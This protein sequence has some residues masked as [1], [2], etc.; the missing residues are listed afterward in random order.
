MKYLKSFIEYDMFGSSPTLYIE[1]KESFGTIFGLIITILALISYFV[2]G[3]YFVLE[4]FD[5]SNV[6]SFTSVQNPTKPLSINFTSDKFY[7][8]FAIQDP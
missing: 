8:G 2:C 3:I 4:M 1:G 7:F 5:K 6:N